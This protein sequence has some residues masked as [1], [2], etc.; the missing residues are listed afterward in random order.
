MAILLIN[1]SYSYLSI[2]L[3]QQKANYH[4]QQEQQQQIHLQTKIENPV[5]KIQLLN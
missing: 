3:E 5:Y 2:K 1:V 4:H